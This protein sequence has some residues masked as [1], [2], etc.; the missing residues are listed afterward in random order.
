MAISPRRIIR[1]SPCLVLGWG[2]RGR[3]SVLWPKCP[4]AVVVVVIV[5]V[6]DCDTVCGRPVAD[7]RVGWPDEEQRRRRQVVSR[8][9]ADRP[10]PADVIPR[11]RTQ[12]CEAGERR[13]PARHDDVITAQPRLADGR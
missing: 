5:V 1:F 10:A 13:L 8:G 12:R 4:A 9:P 7:G 11:E 3:R 6:R 2:F